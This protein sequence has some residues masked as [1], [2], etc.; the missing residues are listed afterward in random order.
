MLK[1]NTHN[2][3]VSSMSCNS[4]TRIESVLVL[5]NTE[6]FT[7][8]PERKVEDLTHSSRRDHLFTLWFLR[9]Y[10]TAFCFPF[11]ITSM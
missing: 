3:T 2:N 8:E 5:L 4:K 6:Y 11:S 7:L 1:K 9:S 10:L